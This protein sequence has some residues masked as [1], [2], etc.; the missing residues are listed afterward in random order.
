M[1]LLG[2]RMVHTRQRQLHRNWRGKTRMTCRNESTHTRTP[3]K[4]K[5][6]KY[7]GTRINSSMCKST[8]SVPDPSCCCESKLRDW[9]KDIIRGVGVWRIGG[10]W[11]LW[12]S[13][14][15]VGEVVWTTPTTGWFP[16]PVI[17]VV[18]GFVLLLDMVGVVLWNGS[19]EVLGT[20]KKDDRC[21]N[22][23]EIWEKL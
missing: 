19:I 12:L 11:D 23:D 7:T 8:N 17:P 18:C 10:W 16:S 2:E 14:I 3:N 22:V 21:G 13:C 5:C 6:S 1:P 20:T 4:S 9:K 15:F